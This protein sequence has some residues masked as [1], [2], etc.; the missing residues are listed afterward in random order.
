MTSNRSRNEAWLSAKASPRPG[1]VRLLGPRQARQGSHPRA[2][3]PLEALNPEWAT[4]L[5]TYGWP[6]ARRVGP[7]RV[8]V[9]QVVVGEEGARVAQ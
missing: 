8:A 1:Y 7:A 5:A 9:D 6:T 2:G 4:K 3:E